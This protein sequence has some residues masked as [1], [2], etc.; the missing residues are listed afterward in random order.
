MLEAIM[1]ALIRQHCPQFMMLVLVGVL[2]LGTSVQPVTAAEITKDL[3]KIP[4]QWDLAKQNLS[5]W[6]SCRL[7]GNAR[8]NRS[9]LPR[10]TSSEMGSTM[11]NCSTR[12]TSDTAYLNLLLLARRQTLFQ[13]GRYTEALQAADRVLGIEP[14]HLT[15]WQLRGDVLVRLGR[16]PEALAAYDRALELLSPESSAPVSLPPSVPANR[17]LPI[18]PPTPI[19]PLKPLSSPLW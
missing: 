18:V 6:E 13:L 4:F 17:V 2:R 14:T 7:S 19:R 9:E 3:S 8:K 5:Q 10:R 12:P 16:Y 15:T 11:G 1:Q